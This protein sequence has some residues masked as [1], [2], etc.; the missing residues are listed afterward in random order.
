MNIEPFKTFP[1]IKELASGYFDTLRSAAEKGK[2]IAWGPALSPY[3]LFRAMDIEYV[4]GEPYGALCAAT[5]LGGEF[6]PAT[7]EYGFTTRFCAYS[8]N[9]IG[10]YL[11]G[12]GPLGELP[13]ADFMVGVRVGCNDHVAWFEA[14]SKMADRPYFAVDLPQCYEQPEERHIAYVQSQLEHFV[15]FVKHVTKQKLEEQ[16]LVEA[17][18]NAHQL[19]V[20]WRE[21]LECCKNVPA[22]LNFK[23]QTSFMIAAVWLKGTKE[24]VDTYAALLDEVKDR[25]QRGVASVSEEKARLLWDNVPM[26]FYPRAL[27]FLEERGLIPVVSP[28]TLLWG[29]N[30]LAYSQYSQSSKDLLSWRVPKTGREAL[31][32]IAKEFIRGHVIMNSL[33][34]KLS[35]YRGLARDYKLDGAI[36]H[37]NWGCKNLSLGRFDIA[38]YLGEEFHLPIH[39]FESSMADP[40]G[41]KEKEFL[42]GLDSFASSLGC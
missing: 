38:R 26:W 12:R 37:S 7:E 15:D 21:I 36:F 3:E 34:S 14:I 28:Y 32:E 23:S 42:T 18:I 35:F 19:R 27:K 11:K 5:G 4:L 30:P 40:R 33:P 20:L 17:V 6:L 8:R 29:D 31:R 24:A 16:R 25:V 41:F 22:P 9:F 2:T 39:V 1:K 10:S 13:K